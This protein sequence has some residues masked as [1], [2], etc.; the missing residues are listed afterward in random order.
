MSDT[1]F[2]QRNQLMAA[3]TATYLKQHLIY[4]QFKSRDTLRASFKVHFF[5]KIIDFRLRPL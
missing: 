1:A 4:Y 3:S 2:V 5:I